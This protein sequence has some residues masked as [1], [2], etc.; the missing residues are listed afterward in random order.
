MSENDYLITQLKILLVTTQLSPHLPTYKR[1][2]SFTKFYYECYCA[3]LAKSSR[4]ECKGCSKS[5]EEGTLR[6][7]HTVYFDEE[8]SH[9]NRKWLHPGCVTLSEKFKN[10]KV[11]DMEGIE[12]LE[13]E[14]RKKI[15]KLLKIQLGSKDKR[16]KHLPK[17]FVRNYKKVDKFGDQKT[18]LKKEWTSYQSAIKKY[19][20]KT[21]SQ[22]KELLSKN[23]AQTSGA[24]EVIVNRCALHFASGVPPNC[25]SCGG[26]NMRLYFADAEYYCPGYLDDTDW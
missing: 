23:N 25:P 22:L 10:L 24:K 7:G 2:T 17:V 1:M 19:S 21:V 4:S 13:E 14:D 12:D 8:H 9:I 15:A 3:E 20:S 5:I 26:Q 16:V 18:L 6:I 11:W